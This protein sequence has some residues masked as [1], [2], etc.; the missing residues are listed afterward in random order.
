MGGRVGDFTSSPEFL[1]ALEAAKAGDPR[2]LAEYTAMM[3]QHASGAGTVAPPPVP[4]ASASDAKLTATDPTNATLA[5]A[6]GH[7]SEATGVEAG[8]VS[9]AVA[10]MQ[11][12]LAQVRAALAATTPGTT[13]A[14]TLTSRAR[15]LTRRIH[16][17]MGLAPPVAPP[18]D[19]PQ[20]A[21]QAA[22]STALTS[23]T[24]PI[25][26][27]LL[28]REQLMEIFEFY[29]NFGR[30]SVMTYQDMLDSFMFMKMCRETPGLLGKGL[31]RT[32]IDLIFTKAKAKTD[33]RLTFSHFLDA[34]SAIAEKKY[35]KMTPAE[36]LRRLLAHHL[37]PLYDM[38]QVEMEKTGETEVPLTGIFKRL[39]DVR[40]YTGVYAERFRS[41]DGRINGETDNRVGRAFDGSTQQDTDENIHDISVLMRPNL[42][43]GTMMRSRARG[44]GGT[45]AVRSARTRARVRSASPNR[46][47]RLQSLKGSTMR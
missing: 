27:P 42:R 21:P 35:P 11:A 10:A 28:T 7:H 18:A 36:G 12:E 47:R 46:R 14:Y 32:E 39:Y 44:Y 37:A 20:A 29:A 23:T 34:L 31:N 13:D 5:R 43:G 2:A 22:P 26:G 25:D 4:G 15:D 30:S 3:A 17:A 41:G 45:T 8:G 9:P 33:R 38:V 6:L 40:S 1:A 19:M 16:E 24:A